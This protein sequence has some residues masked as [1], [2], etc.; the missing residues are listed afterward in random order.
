LSYRKGQPWVSEISVFKNGRT[1]DCR[2]EEYV[3]S[4]E[5]NLVSGPGGVFDTPRSLNEAKNLIT[6]YLED[7]VAHPTDE[8]GG[9]IH[10]AQ[11]T[12]DGFSWIRPP[13]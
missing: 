13:K 8:I 6:L 1:W 9:H 11:F 4:G 2:V 12:S 5:V 7:C 3:P 10:I